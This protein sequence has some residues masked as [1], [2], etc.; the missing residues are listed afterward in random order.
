[1]LLQAV[2]Q[3]PADVR[4]DIS[5]LAQHAAHGVCQVGAPTLVIQ[6][7]AVQLLYGDHERLS[8]SADGCGAWMPPEY[9][10]C[11]TGLLEGG[12]ELAA[13]TALVYVNDTLSVQRYRPSPAFALSNG[14]RQGAFFHFQEWKKAW[15]GQGGYGAHIA[16]VQPLGDAPR[17][18]SRP[19]NFTVTPEGILVIP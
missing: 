15:V 19:R 7:N 6:P 17:Y 16:G 14:C 1:M 2:W 13:T 10:M 9:R 18:S 3:C 4:V 12:A 11:A 5:L 8:I